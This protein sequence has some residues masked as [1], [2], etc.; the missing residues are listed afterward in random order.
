MASGPQPSAL[1]TEFREALDRTA[2]RLGEIG[3]RIVWYPEIGSTNDVAL[4]LAD[5]G[6]PEGCVVVADAQSA[7]RGRRGRAWASPAGAGI[8]ASVVLRPSPAAAALLTLAAGVAVADGIQSATG[9]GTHLKWPNDVCVA[10]ASGSAGGR[11]LAG[12]LAEASARAAVVLGIGINVLPAAYP[13][14]VSSRATSIESE[15]GRAVD[16]GLVLAECLIALAA[17]YGSLQA[18]RVDPVVSAW[19]SRAAPTFGRRVEWDTGSTIQEG[20]AHDIDTDG[21]LLVR[22]ATRVVRVVAGEVRWI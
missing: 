15:L 1:P 4:S 13:P 18:G 21:A 20:V 8:Y 11:K 19:R 7:G 17:R 9:L 12:I 2:G 14:D 3:G 5:A 10:T 22:T 16:R 6:E